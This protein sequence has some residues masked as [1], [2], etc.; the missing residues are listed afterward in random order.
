MW[1]GRLWGANLLAFGENRED[2]TGQKRNTIRRPAGPA[3][4]IRVFMATDYNILKSKMLDYVSRHKEGQFN[5]PGTLKSYFANNH[6]SLDEQDL[7]TIQQ[8][9]HEFYHEGIIIPGPKIG[10]DIIS[11]TGALLFPFYQLTDYGRKVVGDTEYQPHDAEGYLNRIKTDI[12]EIDEVIIR[13]LEEGLSCF[14][15]N[16]LFAAAVMIGCAAE[17]AMLLL[18]EAYGDSLTDKQQKQEYEKETRTFII[19]R[20]WSALWK[21]LEPLSVSFPSELRED[22]GTIL[23]RIFDLIR[24]TR[25]EAGHPTGKHVEKETIHANLLLFPIFCKRLY[26]LIQHFSR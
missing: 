25:N 24:T 20:K 15:K 13:Y 7:R 16:L 21:R 8:I 23:E 17:K 11:Q 12:P 2:N 4:E 18:I 6:V 22:L 5:V 3:N 19:S 1:N 10:K 9:I 14:R 26:G